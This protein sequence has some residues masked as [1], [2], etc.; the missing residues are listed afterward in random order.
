MNVFFA[1]A[2][3]RRNVPHMVR[4]CIGSVPHRDDL[5]RGLEILGE[6]LEGCSDPSANIL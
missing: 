5:R 1:W 3:G 6:V 2:I 4:V